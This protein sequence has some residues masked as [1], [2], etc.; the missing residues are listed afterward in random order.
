MN[1]PTDNWNYDET[2]ARIET[3]IDRIESGQLP[4]EEVFEQFEVAIA[5]LQACEAFLD[6]GENRM[7][8]LVETLDNLN[9][10]TRN[11]STSSQDP[12]F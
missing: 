7:Q 2:V 8:L 3:I 1:S 6:R 11:D 4:L 5:A 12:N 9:S 10:N